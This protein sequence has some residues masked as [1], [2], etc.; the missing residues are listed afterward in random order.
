MQ[1][2]EYYY[3]VDSDLTQQKG[4]SLTF[5]NHGNWK[6]IDCWEVIKP[7][8][9]YSVTHA[10]SSQQCS[11]F[12]ETSSFQRV[13]WLFST[14]H[15]II[16]KP[17]CIKFIHSPKG[18][19]ANHPAVCEAHRQCLTCPSGEFC[20][21]GIASPSV[22]SAWSDQFDSCHPPPWW[23]TRATWLNSPW[24]KVESKHTFKINSNL[25]QIV[26]RESERTENKCTENP[27]GNKQHFVNI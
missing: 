5:G 3:I 10:A 2:S 18:R 16:L 19:A 25:V 15:F 13:S 8:C 26:T 12:E 23:M 14:M 27:T 11:V 9:K 7:L 20:F 21:A 22:N 4:G 24:V 17:T 1:I 6:Q